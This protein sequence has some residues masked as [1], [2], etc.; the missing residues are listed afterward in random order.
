MNAQELTKQFEDKLA[1]AVKKYLDRKCVW[2]DYQSDCGTKLC[3]AI[4]WVMGEFNYCPFCGGQIQIQDN[5]TP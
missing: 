3:P 1:P 5:E 2:T 4:R